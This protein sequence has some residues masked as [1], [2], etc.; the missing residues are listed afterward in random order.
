MKSYLPRNFGQSETLLS[1][2]VRFG[3]FVFAPV[4]LP[5]DVILRKRIYVSDVLLTI[6]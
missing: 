6:E 1:V 3:L 5:P 4:C 2:F